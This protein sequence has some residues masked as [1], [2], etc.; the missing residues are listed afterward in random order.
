MPYCVFMIRIKS[1]QIIQVIYRLPVSI[2]LFVSS[3]P[4]FTIIVLTKG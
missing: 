4:P 3:N 2:G 1:L